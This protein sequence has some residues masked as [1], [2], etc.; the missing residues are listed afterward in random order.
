MHPRGPSSQT[1]RRSFFRSTRDELPVSC[2]RPLALLAAK[3]RSKQ[4]RLRDHFFSRGDPGPPLPERIKQR[5]GWKRQLRRRAAGA[6]CTRGRQC[7]FVQVADSQLLHARAQPRATTREAQTAAARRSLSERT[8]PHVTSQARPLSTISLAPLAVGLWSPS[9]N[10]SPRKSED[11]PS[12]D[13][14]AKSFQSRGTAE[15][16]RAHV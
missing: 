8:L 13:R 1:A 12:R 16:G 11:T 5:R 14:P 6:R 15:I 4:A 10:S 3:S 7:G 2:T 9:K